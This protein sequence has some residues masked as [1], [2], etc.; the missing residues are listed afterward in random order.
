MSTFTPSSKVRKS[1]SLGLV[2]AEYGVGLQVVI[3]SGFHRE[4]YE[5]Q[6]LKY[7][8]S[9]H[10]IMREGHMLMAAVDKACR[11]TSRPSFATQPKCHGVS[12]VVY[13]ATEL[14]DRVPPSQVAPLQLQTSGGSRQSGHVCFLIRGFPRV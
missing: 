1:D 10:N 13:E 4:N 5:S 6:K 7:R 12:L 11:W 2:L 3:P 14:N 9:P 8:R